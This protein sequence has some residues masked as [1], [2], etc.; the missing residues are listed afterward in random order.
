MS[1]MEC[2]LCGLPTSHTLIQAD[3]NSF[4]CS[5]CKMVY[6]S[7][8]PDVLEKASLRPGPATE[9][10]LSNGKEAFLRIEGMHCSS[11][12]I[13]IERL[14]EEIKG[15]LSATSSYATAAAKIVYDPEVIEEAD[16]P[17]AFS[18]AGYRARLTNDEA[19]EYDDRM[20]L[21]RLLVGV[22][23]AGLVM[24]LYLAFF[25][26]SH[27]GIVD[28]E[29]LK[30]VSW[31]AFQVAPWAMFF[32]TTILIVYVA[33][34]IFRGALIGIQVQVLN[35]D[36]LLA[37]AILASYGYSTFQLMN[38]SLDLYFD[39][40]ATLIAVVTI[41]RYVE[42]NAKA[43]A[44][45]ELSK[46]LEKW[47]PKARIRWAGGYRFQAIDD[48]EPGEH[49]IIWES[50]SIPVDGTI[51]YG[52]GA[53]DESLM[54]GEPF[55]VRREPGHEVLGGTVLVEGALEIKVGPVV[56]SQM[57]TLARILWNVQSASNGAFNVADR[58]ARIF[59]PLILILAALVTF[60][61]LM[62]GS[63][64]STAI[65]AGL[66]TL[67]VSCPCTFGLA[68]PLT[69]AIGVSTALR[70]GIIISSADTFE[71][72][73]QIDIVAIDK[74]GT[75]STGDMSVINTVGSEEM[76]ACAAAVERLSPHPIARAIAR[77]DQDKT[78][79]NS[80]SHPGKGAVADVGNKRVAIGSRFLFANLD[81]EIP[82]SLSKQV[83]E[84]AHT[85]G[86][87]SYVGW[88][89]VAQ[90]FIVTRDNDRSHWESIVDH[91]RQYCRVVLLTGAEHPGEYEGKVDQVFSGIP[92][93]GKAVVIRQLRK[94]GSVVM[95]GDGSN[96][97]PALA[98]ADLGIAFGA[99]TTLA[100]EAADVIIPGD[101][102]EQIF[103][104][105]NLIDVIRR[106]V[107][108][109]LVWALLYNAL[110]IPMAVTGV[111]NPLFA[112]FAMSSSSLLVVWN[113]SRSIL[114]T[115][116]RA[117]SE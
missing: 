38:G 39:V 82:D 103:T 89:R 100:A 102:L 24:M 63:P 17:G 84:N 112:A 106:R 14:A 48:L 88:D 1:A 80:E 64:F 5:G 73:R 59:V 77:L 87:I 9:Q 61:F 12:E 117:L 27:L 67:I 68:I 65:L 79:M 26:P 115:K 53:I 76:V 30:P 52:T 50:E 86:V 105:F 116:I 23:L 98:E 19:P 41:G 90:G 25:Y 81:W 44:T 4:C 62:F 51:Q 47:A 13:L 36:N 72:L 46:I 92:P 110:A 83:E 56:E 57:D 60:G 34:P 78:A 32:M 2:K 95:I 113:S 91:L 107:R 6:E 75:L 101:R 7:F 8:G 16:L 18:V 93:E 108:Q 97:A 85:D 33:I 40:A 21:L 58:L 55:P 22:A 114:P 10:E 20:P 104:A 35:M 70:N 31:L 74:T 29:D 71:K 28:M 42:R 15:V 99:P 109:N 11:C 3:G 45:D 49:V 96:D 66:A 54:T 69:N 43:D 94:E 37:I 111:L